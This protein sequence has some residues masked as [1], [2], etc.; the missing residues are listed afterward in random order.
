MEDHPP[1]KPRK[2]PAAAGHRH[3]TSFSSSR[4]VLCEGRDCP[5][6]AWPGVSNPSSIL[7]T[8][9]CPHINSHSSCGHTTASTKR[10]QPL[11]EWHFCRSCW[12]WRKAIE[13]PLHRWGACVP[14]TPLPWKPLPSRSPPLALLLTAAAH[15]TLHLASLFPSKGVFLPIVVAGKVR[16]RPGALCRLLVSTSHKPVLISIPSPTQGLHLAA[17]RAPAIS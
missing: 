11:S 5:G 3:V 13:W 10:P 17:P 8:G 6:E 14:H 15:P 12:C 9:S 16:T 1:S 4:Q 7:P 2:Q